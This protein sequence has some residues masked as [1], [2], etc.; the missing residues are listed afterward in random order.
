M[1]MGTLS[2]DYLT[3]EEIVNFIFYNN[4]VAKVK[5]PNMVELYINILEYRRNKKLPDYI[6]KQSDR[7]WKQQGR[8]I[9]EILMC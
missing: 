1:R 3:K 5:N 9:R 8:Q 7:H 2:S 6:A 4:K